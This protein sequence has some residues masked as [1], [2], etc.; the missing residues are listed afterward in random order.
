MRFRFLLFFLILSLLSPLATIADEI[1]IIYEP[2]K[3]DCESRYWYG[4]GLLTS[5]VKEK[6]SLDIGDVEIISFAGAIPTKKVGNKIDFM[7]VDEEFQ[8]AFLSLKPKG[9]GLYRI[10]F[11]LPKIGSN[12]NVRIEIEGG[13]K[14]FLSNIDFNCHKEGSYLILE[15]KTDQRNLNFVCITKLTYM[16]LADT[17]AGGIFIL[18]LIGYVAFRRKEIRKNIRSRLK[19]SKE[20]IKTKSPFGLEVNEGHYEVSFDLNRLKESKKP[21][22]YKERKLF[23]RI[24]FW[25]LSAVIIIFLLIVF[26]FSITNSLERIWGSL[27]I[28]KIV[29]ISFAMLSGILSGLLLISAKS[30]KELSLRVGIIGGGIVGSMFGY[31]GILAIILAV[32]TCL[33][34]YFLSILLLEEEGG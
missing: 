13:E 30:Y 28:F 16:L 3:I 34:I 14:I 6:F 2:A 19:S 17:F 27:G 4:K 33:L 26:F 22:G 15:A 1:H 29:I 9:H 5:E 21:I 32:T 12:T 31:L 18:V 8:C 25:F 24:P 20:K 7:R 23:F 11:K 10:A